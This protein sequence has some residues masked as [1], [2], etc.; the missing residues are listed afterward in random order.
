MVKVYGVFLARRYFPDLRFEKE[1]GIVG[2]NEI[3]TLGKYCVGES[4]EVFEYVETDYYEKL[5]RFPEDGGSGVRVAQPITVEEALHIIE[6]EKRNLKCGSQL[7]YFEI[8]QGKRFDGL[9]GFEFCGFELT[10][11]FCSISVITG[12][13]DLI[14]RHIS[15]LNGFGLFGTVE[16]AILA[17]KQIKDANPCVSAANCVIYGVW[18]CLKQ[19]SK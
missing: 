10:D 5:L 1:T 12:R 18:R 2:K 8:Y 11:G 9:T 17:R 14:C 7:I 16:E 15:K 3:V 13:K 19:A 4:C 6:M